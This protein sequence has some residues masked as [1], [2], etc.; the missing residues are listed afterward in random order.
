MCNSSQSVKVLAD[1]CE[2][3]ICDAHLQVYFLCLFR[4]GERFS[5]ESAH[6]HPLCDRAVL[7]RLR[8]V[9]CKRVGGRFE[10]DLQFRHSQGAVHYRRGWK[11]VGRSSF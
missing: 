2:Y 5:R 1:F 11:T 3:N 10:S 4:Q 6:A 8:N 7:Q 9:F